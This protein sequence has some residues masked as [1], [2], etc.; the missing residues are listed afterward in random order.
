MNLRMMKFPGSL[1]YYLLFGF[2]L[3]ALALVGRATSRDRLVIER[4][5]WTDL[6]AYLSWILRHI[7]LPHASLII[8]EGR[9]LG[10]VGMI[11]PRMSDYLKGKHGRIF[12]DVGAYHGH[13]SLLLRRNFEQVIAIEP[14]MA[15]ADF[16]RGAIA[17][18]RAGNIKIIRMAVAAEEGARQFGI[19]PQL[20]ESKILSQKSATGSLTSVHATTLD[21]LLGPYQEI[22]LV[23]L[24]VEGAEFDVLEGATDSMSKIRSWMIE[25]HDQSGK[26][27]LQTHMATNGY[28]LLW[29]DQ[30]HLFA[31][32]APELS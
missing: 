18:R 1:L 29:L 32:R 7:G 20:S 8:L 27:K 21:S 6:S 17:Y 23:K 19:M 26:S 13:Y 5:H 25:L 10:T 16:L 28:N 15:N 11:E 3:S 4:L 9:L 24:D 22:D 2:Y 14:V 30:G 31:F 12:V